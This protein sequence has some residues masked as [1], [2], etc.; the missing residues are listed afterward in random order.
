M[1]NNLSP[2]FA[3]KLKTPLKIGSVV[4]ESRVLQSPLSGVTDLVFRRLVRRYAPQSMIYTE[5]VSAKEI[6]HLQT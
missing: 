6:H 2:T 5:M 1:P 3:T 4:L